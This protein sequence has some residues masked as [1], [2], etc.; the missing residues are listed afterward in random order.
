MDKDQKAGPNAV[1]ISLRQ[2][3]VLVLTGL[4]QSTIRRLEIAGEFPRRKKLSI[5]A[6]GWSR[7]EVLAWLMSRARA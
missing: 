1:D 3:E 2:P 6:V 4:S 7:S 5:R